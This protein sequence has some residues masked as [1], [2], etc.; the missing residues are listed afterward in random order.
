M[1]TLGD[2]GPVLKSCGTWTFLKRLWRQ[3]GEDEIFVWASALAY[4]WLFSIFPFLILLLS[5]VPY[6]PDR[7]KSSAQRAIS[8][9]INQ[10]LG[11]EASTINDNLTSIMHDQRR[12]WLGIGLIV[13]IWVSSGGMAMTMSALD[14]CYDITES[15]PYY[16]QRAIAIA[17]MLGVTIGILIMIVLLPIGTAVGEWLKAQRAISPPLQIAFDASRYFLSIVFALFVLSIIYYFGPNIRQRFRFLSPGA[18][19]SAFVWILLDIMF[20][21]YVDRFARYDR[22]YGSVGGAAILLLFFYIDALVL[23]IGAEI[24]SEIDFE[25]LGVPTGSRDFTTQVQ[26]N[27]SET[28]DDSTAKSQ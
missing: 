7:D 25:S 5:L 12:G 20:R 16:K 8:N 4:S 24:N 18:V 23:L 3:V 10:M 6:L 21:F 22:T 13:T 1:A 15:R 26:K 28:R 27:L 9:S 14:R 2:I 19:F 17:V 11:K